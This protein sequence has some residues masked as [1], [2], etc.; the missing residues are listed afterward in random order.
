MT[1]A[2]SERVARLSI[3]VRGV[4]QGV[5]FRPFV[6]R[7]ATERRMTGW[8]RNDSDGVRIEV[9]GETAAVHELV[10]ALRRD[11]PPPAVIDQLEV[12]WVP[13]RPETAFVILASEPG[14]A[15]RPV[16][17]ADLATCGACLAE[18][19]TPGERRYR[20]PFTNCTHCGP[21][22]TIVESLPYDR[23][24][25]SMKGFP[26]CPACT[27][28][29]QSVA[30]RRFH[31]QPIACPACGPSLA[32]W[33]N[34]GV[35][36]ARRDEALDQAAA[37]VRAG[38]VLALK[39]LGGFQLVVDALDEQA[40]SLLRR[41]KRR[42]A[43]PLAVMFPSLEALRHHTD[44]TAEEERALGSPEAPIVLV[45]RRGALLAHGVAPSG[46]NPWI[47]AMLPYTPL[48]RLLLSAID[49]PVVCTS[50]NLSEEPMCTDEQEA[51]ARLGAIADVLLVHDRPIV[52]PVDDSVARVGPGGLELLRRARGF[53]PRSLRLAEPTPTVLALGA[54]LKGAIALA[55]GGEVVVSQ[56]IGDLHLLDSVQLLERSV[57]DLVE[58]LQAKVAV[59]ACDLHPDYASTLLA[60]RLARDLGVPLERVQHHHAH[61]AA[62][63]AEHGITGEVLGLSWDGAGLGT[64]GAIWGGEALSCA[65]A[66][67]R[68]V[69]HLA[70]LALPGGEQA[71]REPRRV[72]LFV[73]RETFG[74][75][76]ARAAAERFGLTPG[77]ACALCEMAAHPVLAPRTTSIGRLFDAVAALAGLASV[78]SFEAEAAMALE[79]AAERAGVAEPYPLPLD[80]GEPAVADWRPLV[81]AVE[82]DRQRGV[83][84]DVIAARFHE[85]LAV[86]AESIALRA[87]V[88]RIV[89]S[90][91]C[92]QNRFLVARIRERLTEQGVEVTTARRYPPNDGGIALG[93]V[94]VAA[95][96]RR[97]GG[98]CH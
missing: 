89:L 5:G 42:A 95:R 22:Y 19:D 43:T 68:R 39:G 74:D 58:F 83:P 85:A 70:P 55:L 81:R 76:A 10:E 4:V 93:Q 9:Q 75:A 33:S 96:R 47:G 80:G 15:V 57:R 40:V 23:P 29:Y 44:P 7:L 66:E 31:A 64:D 67:V 34:R 61:V 56:H 82:H 46:G 59:V 24:R 32:L 72:A 20:H 60:E 25:T 71:V 52:R 92:F 36:L 1:R 84:A 6:F 50:G 69:A 94:L 73:L 48:H 30:D 18:I 78:S 37:A 54:Q 38:R 62:V 27:A 12:E 63:V 91:G 86:L 11:L 49:R 41:R 65:G 45:R 17:P 26:M 87:R 79:F 77:E 13:E 98:P 51:L 88:S 2:Q 21:R 35:Q 3:A 97:A 16:V 53:A 90:G 8:V 28:E 14:T